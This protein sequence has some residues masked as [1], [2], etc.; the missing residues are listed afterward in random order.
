MHYKVQS[1]F[2]AL[3]IVIDSHISEENT[4]MVVH[5]VRTNM[6]SELSA[7][8]TFESIRP[9]FEQHLYFGLENNDVVSTT[10]SAAID[11]VMALELREH[12]AFP[13]N[14]WNPSIVDD[15]LGDSRS[16][17]ERAKEMGYTG[18]E[19]R[20][21]TTAWVK[22]TEGEA[23]KLPMTPLAIMK[24]SYHIPKYCAG[25]SSQIGGQE[26]EIKRG[27]WLSYN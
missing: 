5:L 1:I 9:Q 3:I 6:T 10:L 8:I 14:C 12:N 18:R 27:V 11:F 22:L 26:K 13:K 7:S 4:E 2:R 19:I 25:L 21:P 16:P 23:V 17:M 15:R 24:R 20:E